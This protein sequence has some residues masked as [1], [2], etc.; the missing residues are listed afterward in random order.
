VF[1]EF[2]NKKDA[3]MAFKKMPKKWMSFIAKAINTSPI[4]Q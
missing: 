3:L 1:G 4:I 2:A